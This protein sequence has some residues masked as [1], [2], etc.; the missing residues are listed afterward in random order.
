MSDHSKRFVIDASVGIKLFV[1]EP[2]SDAAHALFGKLSDDPVVEFYVPDLFYVE[3]AN[4]L[5][6][7]TRRI[8]LPFEDAQAGLSDLKLLALKSIPTA[9]LVKE[10]LIL[11]HQKNLSAYD[12]CYIV[13]AQEMN[14]VLVTADQRLVEV[15]ECAVWLGDFA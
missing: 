9:D 5:L 10:A 7:Y 4:I 3:C 2:L 6:K 12:A 11:A 13:L 1:N 8:G 15:V 14:G